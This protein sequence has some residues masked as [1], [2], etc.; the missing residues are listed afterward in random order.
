MTQEV[1]S[2]TISYMGP[3]MITSFVLGM[4]LGGII[5]GSVMYKGKV[6]EE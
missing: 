2:Q 5:I 4:I 1:F 3:F 6:E